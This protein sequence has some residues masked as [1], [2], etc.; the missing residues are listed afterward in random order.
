MAAKRC[1]R[2][3]AETR[4]WREQ[5]R[6]IGR[7]KMPEKEFRIWLEDG[8]VLAW[9][10]SGSGG[11]SSFRVVLLAEIDSEIHCVARYDTAHGVP[12]QDI[13]GLKGGL[14]A[15]NWFFEYG[16]EKVFEYAV[17]DLQTNAKQYISFFRRN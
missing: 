4:W 17:D 15:K 12:H 13:L 5:E 16:I 11:I 2:S 10:D 3:V 1:K 8:L 14:L 6:Q 9:R 7:V